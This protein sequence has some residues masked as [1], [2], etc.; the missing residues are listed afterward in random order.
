MSVL[1]SLRFRIQRMLGSLPTG[2]S[3]LID[4][5]DIVRWIRGQHECVI[6][7]DLQVRGRSDA[8]RHIQLGKQVGIDNGCIVWIAKEEDASPNLM[9]GN[10]AYVGPYSYLGSYEPIEIGENTIIGARAYLI[11][12]NHRAQ[13]G[14]RM[15]QQVRSGPVC[16]PRNLG[17]VNG[18][19]NTH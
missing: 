7:S 6:E 9:L 16:P 14:T 2:R 11:S 19:R 15:C 10:R 12:A 8:L 1:D 13:P 4:S 3:D 18:N 5:R 17:I